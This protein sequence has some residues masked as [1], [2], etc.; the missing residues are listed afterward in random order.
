MWWKLTSLAVVATALIMSVIP[1]RGRAVKFDLS[2][3]ASPPDAGTLPKL[4]GLRWAN[5]YFAPGTV[6]LIAII[7]S[8]AAVIAFRILRAA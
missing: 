6:V 7:L 5:A 4:P 1:I 8:I 2:P 3:D